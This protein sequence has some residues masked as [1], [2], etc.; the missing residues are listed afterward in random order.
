MVSGVFD[1]LRMALSNVDLQLLEMEQ[2]WP[3]KLT[4]ATT[5]VAERPVRKR[6]SFLQMRVLKRR[7]KLMPKRK[8]I[9]KTMPLAY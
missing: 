3:K 2:R 8:R 7:P 5:A 1:V 6:K 4:G 9:K